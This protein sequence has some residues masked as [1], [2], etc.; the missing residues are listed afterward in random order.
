MAS[1]QHD[2]LRVRSELQGPVEVRYL[3]HPTVF[4]PGFR[5]AFASKGGY[6]VL[7]DSPETIGR[8]Q[9]PTGSATDADEVP[10]LRI[11]ASAWRKYLARHR[12]PLVEYLAG[13]KGGDP[14][15]LG[16]HLDVLMPVLEGL[17]RLELVQRPGPNRVAFVLRLQEAKK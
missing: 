15:E 6:I 11:S 8:F 2:D 17:D 4:P 14:K 9:P 5:P 13:A 3:T 10:I 12:G 7:A 1:L 16:Q